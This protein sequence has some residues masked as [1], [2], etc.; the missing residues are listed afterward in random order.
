MAPTIPEAGKVIQM[1]AFISLKRMAVVN[2]PAAMNPACPRDICPAYPVSNINAIA[3]MSARKTWL[4]KSRRNTD[5]IKGKTTNPIMRTL[6][7][8]QC[9]LVSTRERSLS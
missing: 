4:A 9:A 8:I 6:R 2:A 1:D 3:P 5:D 7:N